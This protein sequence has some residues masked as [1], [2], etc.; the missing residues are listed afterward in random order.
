M[1]ELYGVDDENEL[2][3]LEEDE[4]RDDVDMEE[5]VAETVTVGRVY[6][7]KNLTSNRLLHSI[8]SALDENNYDEILHLQGQPKAYTAFFSPAKS[9]KLREEISWVDRPPQT[10]GRQR[11]CDVINGKPEIVNSRIV[12]VADTERLSC[13]LPRK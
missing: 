12:K 6:K 4:S 7:K 10:I 11:R 9:G 2:S 13:L 1:E 5:N 3:Y 8:S